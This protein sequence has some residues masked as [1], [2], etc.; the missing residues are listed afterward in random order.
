MNDR[1][2]M[3]VSDQLDFWEL[4]LP[5]LRGVGIQAAP[6]PAPVPVPTPPAEPNVAAMSMQEFAQYRAERGLDSSDFVG[7]AAWHYRHLPNPTD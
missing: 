3:T 2:D 7:V 5:K 6:E 4:H 1:N